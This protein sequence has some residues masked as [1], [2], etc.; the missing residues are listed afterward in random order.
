M[1]NQEWFVQSAADE[2]KD[3]ARAIVATPL[4]QTGHVTYTTPRASNG[5]TYKCYTGER[6]D[7]FSQVAQVIA[8]DMCKPGHEYMLITLDWYEQQ[9]TRVAITLSKCHVMENAVAR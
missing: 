8:K 7:V 9:D 3:I 6:F 2:F 1:T 5:C 4:M